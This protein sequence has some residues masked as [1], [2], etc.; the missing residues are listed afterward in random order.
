MRGSFPWP[1]GSN[2]SSAVLACQQFA[3]Q[4]IWT[5]ASWSVLSLQELLRQLINNSTNLTILQYTVLSLVPFT[6]WPCSGFSHS[7]DN[8][9]CH[10]QLRSC[11]PDI[12]KQD[13]QLQQP[14]HATHSSPGSM[15]PPAWSVRG[16]KRCCMTRPLVVTV[17]AAP[18]RTGTALTPTCF[19]C[20]LS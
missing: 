8:S 19:R 15:M 10:T 11:C 20:S 13:G 6:T 1:L 5:S 7:K 4:H 3:W 17:C 9:S 12:H 2:N 14:H 18:A 16:H